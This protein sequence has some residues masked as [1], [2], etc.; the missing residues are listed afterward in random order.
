MDPDEFLQ[1]YPIDTLTEGEK[2][3]LTIEFQKMF[4][5]DFIIRNTDRLNANYLIKVTDSAAKNLIVP[6][7]KQEAKEVIIDI[8]SEPSSSSGNSYNY[9]LIFILII[10]STQSSINKN[11]VW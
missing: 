7:S 5:L 6:E 11:R 10:F 9:L 1:L 3:A 2:K 4:T 8:M